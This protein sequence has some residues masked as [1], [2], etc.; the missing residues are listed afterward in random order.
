MLVNVNTIENGICM[1]LE[2]KVSVEQSAL[3]LR[4]LTKNMHCNTMTI[5]MRKVESIDMVIAHILR[6]VGSNMK[7][8]GRRLKVVNA[9]ERTID[10]TVLHMLEELEKMV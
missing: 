2:G 3:L 10:K 4:Y 8:D 6:I 7:R 9:P 1:K 5:D